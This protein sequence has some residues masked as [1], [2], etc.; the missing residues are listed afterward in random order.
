MK[1]EQCNVGTWPVITGTSREFA[2]PSSYSKHETTSPFVLFK[3]EHFFLLSVELYAAFCSF[4]NISL[5]LLT[6]VYPT[7]LNFY[8]KSI[9]ISHLISAHLVDH[10]YVRV[11]QF[12]KLNFLA[13]LKMKEMK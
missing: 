8:S 1:D 3:K 2:I 4:F 11:L 9:L 12:E 10:C 13:F 7:F 6:L 5:F